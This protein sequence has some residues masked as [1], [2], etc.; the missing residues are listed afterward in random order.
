MQ[1]RY[2]L[3]FITIF[4]SGLSL[5]GQSTKI[6]LSYPVY[7]QYLHNGLLINPAYAGSRDVLS[8]FLSDRMQWENVEG[9]PRSQ[10]ASFHTLSKNDR[11]GFGLS[12]QRLIYG[13]KDYGTSELYSVY[14]DYAYHLKLRN[15]KLSLGL[16]AGF[17]HSKSGFTDAFRKTLTSYTNPIPAP[18]PVFV[19]DDKPYYLFNAGAGFYYYDKKFFLGAAI[20][21]FLGYEK[22]G[23][24]KLAPK[25]FSDVDVY[26]TAGGL[27]T[28]SPSFKFKP[29]VFV[30][31]SVQRTRGMRIDLNGNFIIKDFLWLGGSWRTSENV[32]I[33]II[34]L[35][36]NPQ[37]MFGYS[38]DYAVGRMNTYS[39]GSHEIVLRYE[40]TYKVSAANPKYF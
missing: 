24:S 18:D 7:S 39:K 25:P 5:S 15:G 10:T 8:F 12:G 22:S 40:F 9:A 14:A 2:L 28:F 16:K 33:G 26:V 19:N 31:Y 13:T 23:S 35:Q 29:S 6:R 32:A 11:V 3:F 27:I 36:I 17:D 20:P 1:R 38:Y 4:L 21:Q 37:I 30:D 34:Q